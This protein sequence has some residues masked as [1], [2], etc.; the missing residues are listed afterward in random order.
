MRAFALPSFYDGRVRINLRGRERNGLVPLERYEAAC[1]E[2]VALLNECRDPV[3]G[4]GAVECFE[5]GHGRNRPL[6]L[7][8][9]DADITVVWKRATLA[10][11]HPR[12][13]RMGPF[14]FRRTGGHTGPFGMAYIASASLHPGDRGERS[15]FDV[16]PTLFDLLGE[17]PPHEISGRS[18]LH[19]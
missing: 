16:V 3:S 4:D 5:Y 17:K 13:G 1:G 19:S 6:D 11:D 14:P 15:A 8:P 2:I 7:N 9:T 18:L 12:L 10:L